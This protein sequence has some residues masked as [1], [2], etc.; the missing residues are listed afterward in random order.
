M[1]ARVMGRAMVSESVDFTHEHTEKR[2]SGPDEASPWRARLAEL[3]VA[4]RAEAL[5][6]WVG[7]VVS[8]ALKDKAPDVLDPQR[9]F[10]DL[11]FDSLATVDLHARLTA[12][13]GLRLPVPIA[14]DHPTPADL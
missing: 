11:G 7:E 1:S 13:T 4:E 9:P 2:G 10:L 8:Q 3:P 12:A 6:D 5:T 14:F